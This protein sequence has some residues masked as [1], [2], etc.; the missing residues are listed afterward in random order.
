M[1]TLKKFLLI[2]SII[3]IAVGMFII[4]RMG[5]KYNDNYT[6]SM[7]LETAKSYALYFTISTIVILIYLTIRYS[8]QG[9]GKVLTTS[10]LSIVGAI[11]FVLAVIAISRMP[12]SRIIFSF[13]LMTYVL[14]II[15]LTANF[16]K[17]I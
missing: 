11:A 9:I 2:I 10:V 17:N 1:K 15:A 14:A 12:V 8:K 7:L 5:F 13:I 4:G 3:I 16:E 6:E